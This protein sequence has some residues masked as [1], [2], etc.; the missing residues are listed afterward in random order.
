[1][2]RKKISHTRSLA[3]KLLPFLFVA[4]AVILAGALSRVKHSNAITCGFGSDIGGGRCRGYL[5]TS[6]SVQ[7]WT[8]PGDWNSASNTIELIA[9]GASGNAGS[10]GGPGGTGNGGG[11]GGAY[12][13][14]TNQA[15]S[16]SVGYRVGAA[17]GP[18]NTFICNGNVNCGTVNGSN[19][20]DVI[21][22]AC[23]GTFGSGTSGGSG[24]VSS[25]PCG[26]GSGVSLGTATAGGNGGNGGSGTPGGGGGG[27][28]GRN[29]IGGDGS[30]SN[31]GGGD[32][33]NGGSG[34]CP[35]NNGTEWDA[36]HGSGGGGNGG[37]AAAGCDGGNY[38][39]GGG[40]GQG[41]GNLGGNGAQGLIVITYAPNVASGNVQ[42]S[43]RSDTLS[44]S[45]MST[46]SNHA[47]SFKTNTNIAGSNT[48]VFGLPSS[49]LLSNI[50]CGDVDAA[51]SSNFNFNYPACAATATA[52]GFSVAGSVATL[53]APTD[54]AVHVATGTPMTIW[55][56]SSATS[57][58]Q[59]VHWI[60]NPSSGGIYTITVGGTFLGSGNILVSINSAVTV[61]AT[62][63]ESLS[64]SVSSIGILGCTADD[65]ATVNSVSTTGVT[66]PF[67]NISPNTFYIGCH[68]LQVSTNA[69]N[70]Y[71]L[72]AQ[73]SRLLSTAQFTIPNTTCDNGACTL[74]TA[75]AWTNAA[76]NGFGHTC[77]N[78]TNHDC[79]STYSSGS[80]F[81]P[82]ANIA[83]GD[84]A[85][86]VMS[87]STAA[88]ATGRIK[89]RLSAGAAQAAGLYTTIIAYIITGTY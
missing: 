33:G 14:I 57:Q 7:N 81:R 76:K 53:T 68:D 48:V 71:S 54:S 85:Q 78:Q 67:G 45:R 64:L 86:A 47:I 9:S 16:G 31:G 70:G 77:T 4:L 23:G 8:V 82:L 29:G 12:S 28:A 44:D 20:S 65:G 59:G 18:D 30:A 3:R 34:A 69:G 58:R 1:M 60:T 2:P 5:T 41:S 37:S 63:A 52:W 17:G 25:G 62:I 66:V 49:F 6:G 43:S 88:T 87:S 40:G 38:G 83:A 51:T 50:D 15:L 61:Q 42:V 84:T 89:Y 75:G 24:G 21:G 27:A 19:G 73:E 22:L 74:L 26:S 56:G 80:N 72:T 46:T 11:G 10:A 35:G 39:A 36:T 32:N 55:I 13:V 79:A